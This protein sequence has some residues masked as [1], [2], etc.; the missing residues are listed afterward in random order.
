MKAR[1][2]AQISRSWKRCQALGECL[3]FGTTSPERKLRHR[4]GHLTG[5]HKPP[6]SEE[7]R[8]TNLCGQPG[9]EIKFREC[10]LLY[11]L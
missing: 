3:S 11:E 9:E 4:E 7:G 2:P 5:I 8:R 1:V 6:R 10:I